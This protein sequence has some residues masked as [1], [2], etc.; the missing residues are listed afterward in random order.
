MPTKVPSDYAKT[1][2]RSEAIPAVLAAKSA[3]VRAS[4]SKPGPEG[5]PV[6]EPK[7][8]LSI[9][10]TWTWKCQQ[11]WHDSF[12]AAS[13]TLEFLTLGADESLT[14]TLGRP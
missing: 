13:L 11:R 14:E 2:I 10:R 3:R 8:R 1:I 5:Q 12:A 4:A 7:P 9:A 6:L